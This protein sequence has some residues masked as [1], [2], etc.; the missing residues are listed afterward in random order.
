[1]KLPSE[2][3]ETPAWICWRAEEKDG[4]VTK[5]PVAPWA[6]GH[7]EGASITDP[8]NL[9]TFEQALRTARKEDLDGIG[10]V[11][12]E[13]NPFTGIDFDRCVGEDGKISEEAEEW[14]RRFGSYAEL[15]PSK[16]GIHVI[17][18]GRLPRSIKDEAYG[19]EAYSTG[20]FFTIT[21]WHLKITPFKVLERQPELD[22]F[23]ERYKG[24]RERDLIKI[25]KKAPREGVG[26]HSD[27]KAV[28]VATFFR[29]M[30]FAK[31]KAL[32]KLKEWWRTSPSYKSDEDA[33]DWLTKKVESAYRPK[34]PYSYRFK[35]DPK[36]YQLDGL[37]LKKLPKRGTPKECN[38]KKKEISLDDAIDIYLATP[39]AIHPTIDYK[40]GMSI[41]YGSPV[42]TRLKEIPFI[43]A[44][45]AFEGIYT[46]GEIKKEF[47][48]MQYMVRHEPMP[49]SAKHTVQIL[50]L[51]RTLKNGEEIEKK[52]IS[53]LRNFLSEKH[54][55]YV[56]HRDRR[57]YLVVNCWI[58]G[59]YIFPMFRYY[60]LLI[61]CGLRGTGKS[62]M[63]DFITMC[64]FNAD[65][66]TV[67]TS[68]S[69]FFR[70]IQNT[71]SVK[72]IDNFEKL[73]V[74]TEKYEMIT[75]LLEACW[76]ALGVV[77]R[78]NK[79]THMPETFNVFVPVAI[80]SRV[81]KDFFREKGIVLIT[82][83]ADDNV[84]AERSNRLPEDPDFE[85]IRALC[86]NFGLHYAG[87]VRRVYQDLKS[88]NEL[89]GRQFNLW[90]P[91]LAVCK[92]LFPESYEELW[93]FAIET[94]KEKIEDR[95][96]LEDVILRILLERSVDSATLTEITSWVN[97]EK[98][99]VKYQS[100]GAAI[101]KLKVVKKEKKKP[102]TY[103]FDT[104]RIKERCRKRRIKAIDG[105]SE[106]DSPTEKK[107]DLDSSVDE[108]ALKY[109]TIG[110]ETYETK[111]Q[112]S[113]VK[114]I[115]GII[116]K[117]GRD[118]GTAKLQEIYDWCSDI[119]TH[120][121]VDRTLDLL[122]RDGIIY[123]PNDNEYRAVEG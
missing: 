74:G 38:K 82:E 27:D 63:L 109:E 122:I 14:I 52:P 11:F 25:L 43:S 42:S 80:G 5:I 111:T 88:S 55:Y 97:E 44:K 72:V 106:K 86:Y 73:K 57:Y 22:A 79:E 26:E 56:Y 9:T 67:D 83:E 69:S 94:T 65:E 20:R 105:A 120:E 66:K 1:M 84:F 113:K 71:R 24:G 8:K 89:Y 21:G 62:T 50:S 40:E 41:C 104:D 36:K 90:R 108:G 2:L 54:G 117:L 95:R 23:F 15:S 53:E 77:R 78:T 61:F 121:E 3:T 49:A 92:V 6:T 48:P 119:F 98:P 75:N 29:R 7:T 34:E 51:Y 101:K 35:Q 19:I 33:I 70:T 116:K 64:A 87:E 96:D 16:K 47:A 17:V 60:P 123:S 118:Y 30:G 99:S 46:G 110:E 115:L 103:W 45:K 76:D 18:K 107:A 100:V 32:E 81:E 13:D 112:C 93:N 68:Q 59:T 10:F 102:L 12:T 4:H 85:K 114:T 37:K 58:V 91:L 31:E 28:M 39:G